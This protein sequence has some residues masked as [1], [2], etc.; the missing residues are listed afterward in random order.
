MND[1]VKKSF[2]A[3]LTGQLNDVDKKLGELKAKASS[4]AGTA[5]AEYEKTLDELLG[6]RKEAEEQLQKLKAASEEGWKEL[7]RGTRKAIGSISKSI[8]NAIRKFKK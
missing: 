4:A 3:K 2:L 5:K 1:T 7:K 6:K 8:A